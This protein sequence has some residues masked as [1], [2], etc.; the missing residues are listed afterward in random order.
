[1]FGVT[2]CLQTHVEQ[3]AGAM[4]DGKEVKGVVVVIGSKVI[5]MSVWVVM[6]GNKEWK[7]VVGIVGLADA[8]TTSDDACLDLECTNTAFWRSLGNTIHMMDVNTLV[9]N[10]DGTN[11]VDDNEF[12]HGM[13]NM[14]QP[15]S[16]CL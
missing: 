9:P 2:Q 7:G 3:S 12:H 14:V 1:M 8:A 4:L 5:R 6:L 11:L 13:M 16:G 10:A 15:E